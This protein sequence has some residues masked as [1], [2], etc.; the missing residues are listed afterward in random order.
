MKLTEEDKKEIKRTGL[1]FLAVMIT[2]GWLAV[3]AG[4]LIIFR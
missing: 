3:I 2:I 1:R 4:V